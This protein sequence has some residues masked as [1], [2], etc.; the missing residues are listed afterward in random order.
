MKTEVKKLWAAALRSGRYTQGQGQLARRGPEDE[1][2]YCCLGVLCELA[3][4]AGAVQRRVPADYWAGIHYS[5]E[6]ALLPEKVKEWA[7]IASSFDRYEVWYRGLRTSA[8]FMEMN[9][10]MKFSFEDIA[11]VI[12][13]IEETT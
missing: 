13:A 1:V 7:G 9:D 3:A 4:E 5:G 10:A 2:S 12:D 8:T 11:D 6:T